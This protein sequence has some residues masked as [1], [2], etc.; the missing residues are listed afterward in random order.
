MLVFGSGKPFSLS[1]HTGILDCPPDRRR[2]M[3]LD[4]SLAAEVSQ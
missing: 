1:A 2:D 3:S 4:M